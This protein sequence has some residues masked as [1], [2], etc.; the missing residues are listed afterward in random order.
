MLKTGSACVGV[1]ILVPKRG[2]SIK[3]ILLSQTAHSGT[4]SELLKA[5]E[6]LARR[7]GRR[8]I[9][10]LVSALAAECVAILISMNYRSEGILREPYRASDDLLILS[11]IF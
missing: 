1:I 6:D 2:G 11:K 7:N 3:G 5:G 4:I 10:Y 9:Y 8:K